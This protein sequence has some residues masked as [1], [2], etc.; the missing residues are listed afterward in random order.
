[1][2]EEM[3][4]PRSDPKHPSDPGS[5]H[6][7]VCGAG[8]LVARIYDKGVFGCFGMPRISRIAPGTV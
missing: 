5:E 6:S 2:K 8:P 3:S 1:V 7:F 4:Q